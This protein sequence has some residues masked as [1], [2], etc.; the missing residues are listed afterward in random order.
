MELR[1]ARYSRLSILARRISFSERTTAVF[2]KPREM[3]ELK[4][5]EREEVDI[6]HAVPYDSP[7]NFRTRASEIL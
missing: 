1:A 6:I 2:R 4:K 3:V 5:K 7:G